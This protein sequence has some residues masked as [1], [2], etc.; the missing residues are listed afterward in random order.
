MVSSI[1]YDIILHAQLINNFRLGVPLVRG[2]HFMIKSALLPPY[3]NQ[4]YVNQLGREGRGAT[5]L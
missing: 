4:M 2:I 3:L 1:M 5:I